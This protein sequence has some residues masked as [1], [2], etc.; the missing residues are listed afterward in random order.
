MHRVRKFSRFFKH[1]QSPQS[2]AQ[3][4]P[5]LIR[6]AAL[7]I[8]S[9]I[10][11]CFGPLVGE[12]D[13]S[14]QAEIGAAQR[15][16]RLHHL[17]RAGKPD[18]PVVERIDPSATSILG[19]SSVI[20]PLAINLSLMLDLSAF[21]HLFERLKNPLPSLAAMAILAWAS[22]RRVKY[23]GMSQVEL[24]NDNPENRSMKYWLAGACPGKVA[25]GFPKKGMRQN[26]KRGRTPIR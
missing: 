7:F 1:T 10:F 5:K 9:W 12:G 20:S 26:K 4:T 14:P 8:S 2:E 16:I 11:P 15:I 22:A 13:L 21:F 23:H 18:L 6:N 17:H 24:I 3:Q 25:A 19:E